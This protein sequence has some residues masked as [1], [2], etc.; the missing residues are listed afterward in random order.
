M[1]TSNGGKKIGKGDPNG[2][3][4]VQVAVPQ[5]GKRKERKCAS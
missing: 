4:L 5:W 2:G 1:S 3:Q